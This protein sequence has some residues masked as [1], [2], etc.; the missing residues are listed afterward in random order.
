MKLLTITM[1]AVGAV[2]VATTAEAIDLKLYT[3]HTETGVGPGNGVATT[4]NSGLAFSGLIGDYTV[5]DV[6][7]GVSESNFS[8][9]PTVAD[10]RATG[11]AGSYGSFAA[12]FTGSVLAAGGTYH[13]SLYSDDGSYMYIDNVLQISRPGAHGPDSTSADIT[14]SAGVHTVE[15]Q[16][17]ECCGGP[18]GVDAV[19]PEG[20]TFVPPTNVVPDGASTIALLG[21]A[22]ALMAGAYRRFVA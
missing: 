10:P 16:F 3:D 19:L 21:G 1:V 5:S 18:S 12:D 14:L 13:I 9:H 22:F 15:V 6:N 4:A 20:V 8:W 17:F 7:F 11:G 2:C